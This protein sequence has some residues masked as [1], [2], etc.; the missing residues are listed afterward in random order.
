MYKI[1]VV[2]RAVGSF[3]GGRAVS[4]QLIEFDSKGDAQYAL[5]QL[6]VSKTAEWTIVKL[7][8]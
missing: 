5:E 7:W 1:L 2:I 4:Q 8:A 6:F 3:D